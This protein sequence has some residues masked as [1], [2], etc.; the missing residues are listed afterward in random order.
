MLLGCLRWVF[1]ERWKKSSRRFQ[2]EIYIKSPHF[3]FPQQL[4]HIGGQAECTLM[5]SGG[6]IQGIQ[7]PCH[8][9][10]CVQIVNRVVLL[11]GEAE[12]PVAGGIGG[13][14]SLIDTADG[15]AFHNALMGTHAGSGIRLV[16]RALMLIDHDAVLLQRLVAV[17]IKLLGK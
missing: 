12:Q 7:F 4:F 8:P 15:E 3:H 10:F 2:H 1:S 9:A 6:V 16:K 13:N 5:E 11:G 14:V 17:S